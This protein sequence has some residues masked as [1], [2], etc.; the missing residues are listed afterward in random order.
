MSPA[1]LVLYK[2]SLTFSEEEHSSRTLGDGR[3]DRENGITCA[4]VTGC[5]QF[6][7]SLMTTGVLIS[8]S[9]A[10]IMLTLCAA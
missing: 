3:A 7:H 8:N 9:M 5:H 10:E 2:V 1:E 6:P 4:Y